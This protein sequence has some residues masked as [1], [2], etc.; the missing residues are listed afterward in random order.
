[1]LILEGIPPNNT[2]QLIAI[3]K[4]NKD[5]NKPVPYL[6]TSSSKSKV[7]IIS[8]RVAIISPR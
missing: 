3:E 2:D 6:R 5:K 1:M 8:T 7:Y 4:V